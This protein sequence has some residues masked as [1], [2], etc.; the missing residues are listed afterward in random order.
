MCNVLVYPDSNAK[1]KAL[2][3]EG[4]RFDSVLFIF[5]GCRRYK[6]EKAELGIER[7]SDLLIRNRGLLSLLHPSWTYYVYF[8]DERQTYSLHSLCGKVHR[9]RGK[10]L[11]EDECHVFIDRSKHHCTLLYLLEGEPV[12]IHRQVGQGVFRIKREQGAS[13]YRQSSWGEINLLLS[14]VKPT[15]NMGAKRGKKGEEE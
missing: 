7:A 9:L 8:L 11:E 4:N 12:S 14:E 15:G 6:F 10:P 3:S 13:S 1:L 5:D 2:L